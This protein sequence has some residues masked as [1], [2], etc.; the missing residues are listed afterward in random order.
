M[1]VLTLCFSCHVQRP[2]LEGGLR[3]R[4][5][6]NP[7]SENILDTKFGRRRFRHRRDRPHCNHCR[8]GA[9]PLQALAAP[10]SILVETTLRGWYMKSYARH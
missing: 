10:L 1:S 4:W 8:R 6:A 5:I 2:F 7:T 3:T 9:N